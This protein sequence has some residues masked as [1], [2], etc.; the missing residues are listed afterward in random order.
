MFQW[1]QKFISINLLQQILLDIKT[2]QNAHWTSQL[3]NRHCWFDNIIQRPP[4]QS[5]TLN[6]PK[7]RARAR[8]YNASQQPSRF[9]QVSLEPFLNLYC[10]ENSYMARY[11]LYNPVI[12]NGRSKFTSE[13]FHNFSPIILNTLPLSDVDEIRSARLFNDYL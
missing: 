9:S 4:Y 1:K 12:S 11:R 10:P 3:K 5:S 6:S 7:R 8:C 13:I 2:N